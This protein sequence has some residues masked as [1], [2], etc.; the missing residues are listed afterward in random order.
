MVRGRPRYG[1]LVDTGASAALM[2]TDVFK[3]MLDTFL[4]PSG[5][6]VSYIKSMNT[7]T[8]IDGE[9]QPSLSAAESSS[10]KRGS[11]SWASEMRRR[12]GIG[13]GLPATDSSS[14]KRS[15]SPG[16]VAI[17]CRNGI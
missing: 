9:A 13:G 4:G 8:G 3:H 14:A 16:R 5:R 17:L 11:S 15:S 12:F 2:G 6:K 1:F 7:F 10:A